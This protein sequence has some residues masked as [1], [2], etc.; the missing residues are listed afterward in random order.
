MQAQG[1]SFQQTIKPF[2]G[3]GYI[4][5]KYRIKIALEQHSVLDALSTDPPKDDTLANFKMVDVKARSIITQ[6]LADNVLETV[7]DK[8]TAKEMFEVLDLCENLCENWYWKTSRSSEKDKK[9]KIL[10]KEAVSSRIYY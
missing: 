2:D 9:F 5:W 3:S 4:Y 6:S 10:S 1:G 7:M 8:P